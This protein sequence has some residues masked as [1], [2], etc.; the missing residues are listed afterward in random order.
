MDIG[1]EFPGSIDISL[2]VHD[3]HSLHSPGFTVE[4]DGFSGIDSKTWVHLD[5]ID[6]DKPSYVKDNYA[7]IEAGGDL[8]VYLR[9]GCSWPVVIEQNKIN[10]DSNLIAHYLGELGLITVR[11]ED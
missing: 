4:R 9:R 2:N 10:A 6:V 7:A 3:L 5:A 1:Y 8:H 11:A